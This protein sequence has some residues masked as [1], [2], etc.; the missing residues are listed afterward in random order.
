MR[1]LSALALI[2]LT[3][4]TSEAVIMKLTPLAEVLET[5]DFIFVAKL[6]KLDTE[7]PLAVFQLS[8]KLKGDAPFDRIAV[9]M[10]GNAEAKKKNDTKAINER[11]DTTRPVVLFVSKRGKKY[12]A[13]AFVEGTW[14]SLQGTIDDTDKTLRWG[15]QNGEPYLRRTFKGTSA[16][17]IQVIEDGLSKKAKPPE[18]NE[19][20]E[21][22]YGPV[23]EKAE[24]KQPKPR[25]HPQCSGPGYSGVALFGVI[26]SFVLVGPLAI[27]AALFPGVFARMAVGMKRWRAFLVIASINSTLAL[28]YWLVN[29]YW[30]ALL[31]RG[32]W[33]G[34]QAFTLYLMIISAVGLSWAG[35]R[36][37]RMASTEPHI[38]EPPRRTELL[39][40]IG[41]S[42][43]VLLCVALT[44]VFA[45]WQTNLELPM[46]EFTFIGFALVV[47]TAYAGYR[48]VTAPIDHSAEGAAP[49]RRLS[50]SGESVGLA[51]LLLCGLVA[52]VSPASGP[53]AIV[54]GGTETGD[55]ESVGPRL[56]DVK[57]FAIPRAT[58]VM[59]GITV[60]GD[61]LYFGAQYTR[62]RAEGQLICLNR[63]TGA[64]EW[65][66]GDDE[67]MIPAFCT[68]LVADGRVY[69]G[70]GLHEDKGCRLFC[71][72]A[73]DGQPGWDKPYATNSHTEG[74]PARIGNAVIFPAGDDGL[75]AVD[76]TTGS[77]LWQ[78]E[79]GKEKG[80]HIDAAPAVRGNRVFIGSGLYSFVAACIDA[81]TGQEVWRTDLKQRAFGAPIVIGKHVYYGIG[82]GNM[83]TDTFNYSEEGSPKEQLDQPGGA[84][85]CLD[86]ETGQEVWRHELTRSVHTGLVGDAFSIYA[87]SRNGSVN[88]ID[89]KTGKLR[90]S[91]GI[92]GAITS[93]PAVATAGGMP[94]AVYAV[95]REG[96]AVCLNPHTGKPIWQKPLPGFLWDGK[97]GN[98]VLAAPAVVTTLTPN[99]S[100]RAIYFGAMTI[101]PDNSA[102]KT[103]AIFRFE[104]EIAI[105]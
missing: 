87:C 91:T 100:K 70:E 20:E 63:E 11:L 95:S 48:M 15:F 3:S 51:T 58:Q 82:T 105:D 52:V 79:G 26:P 5:E 49:E 50:L 75:I 16:E 83:V 2:A 99:G 55:A 32:W 85:V 41:L 23:A 28:L 81:E 102:R 97:D 1:F 40:L 14:F 64:V 12:N 47:A 22:G 33:F 69:C 27:V 65:R 17:L 103:C 60:V 78:Y 6:E 88:A 46:R 56:V 39:T 96:N 104:D 7:K 13:M 94:V 93:A 9:N 43:F 89:R 54:S 80:I 84:V 25:P 35:R 38:T 73:A 59:S 34:P 24:K 101:D 61:R 53:Q 44:A 86:A 18:P 98:G 31:P 36:Y 45:T 30:P 8:K 72:N 10:S 71:V 90:W 57:V 62:A 74:M 67:G 4:L 66:F 92:G 42:A 68:P 37:R 21:P 19:K 76:A 77:R 29:T